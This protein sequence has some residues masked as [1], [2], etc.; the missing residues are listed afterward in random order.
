[1]ADIQLQLAAIENREKEYERYYRI[2]EYLHER[3]MQQLK[4]R[5]D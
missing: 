4:E 5:D 2:A 3:I 1:M